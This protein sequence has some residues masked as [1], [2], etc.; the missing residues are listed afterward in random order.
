LTN[1]T[2]HIIYVLNICSSKIRMIGRVAGEQFDNM[3]KHFDSSQ[4]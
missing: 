2:L 4:V 1:K 3:F